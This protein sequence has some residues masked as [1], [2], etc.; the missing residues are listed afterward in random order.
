MYYTTLVKRLRMLVF[1]RRIQDD[2]VWSDQVVSVLQDIDQAETK[3]T[4]HVYRQR[5]Q[6]QE[7]KPVNNT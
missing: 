7:E 1:Q 4:D 6:K 5:H 2:V 3:H